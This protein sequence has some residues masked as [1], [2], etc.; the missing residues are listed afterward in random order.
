MVPGLTGSHSFSGS[1]LT[2]KARARAAACHP[3]P[4][5]SQG[6]D[7]D[8]LGILKMDLFKLSFIQTD[9]VS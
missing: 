1:D 8:R 5:R 6:L 2:G 9:I 3:P 7:Q 4:D